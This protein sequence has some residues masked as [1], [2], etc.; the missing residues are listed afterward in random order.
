MSL[1]LSYVLF[2]FLKFSP[3]SVYTGLSELLCCWNWT[4][5]PETRASWE[6]VRWIRMVLLP[7]LRL[8]SLA[9]HG[10]CSLHLGSS[11][12]PERIHL[13]EGISCGMNGKLPAL[14][15][16]FLLF[17]HSNIFSCLPLIVF[18]LT[19]FLKIYHFILK[20]HFIYFHS[21]FLIPL[22]F[23]WITLI[24]YVR[25]INLG[26]ESR[27]KEMDRHLTQIC[28]RKLIVGN[29]PRAGSADVC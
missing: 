7:G 26:S 16:P 9:V 23:V 5:P 28:K 15:L 4:T 19:F 20:I 6:C 17:F 2:Y 8:S 29:W 24:P 3:R 12:Q 13:N 22:K 11:Y 14:Q 27:K 10:F 21:C 1:L 18:N 25:Q